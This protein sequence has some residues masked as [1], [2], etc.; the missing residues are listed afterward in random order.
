MRG[1]RLA[2]PPAAALPGEVAAACPGRERYLQL[3]QRCWA[4]DPSQRPAF[5]QVVVELKALLSLQ[6]PASPPAAALMTK[7]AA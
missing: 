7:P 2:L 6:A 4:Q 5:S 3:M 1:D